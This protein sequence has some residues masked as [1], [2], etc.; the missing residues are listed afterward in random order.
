MCS[1]G[2]TEGS[3]ESV[4]FEQIVAGRLVETNNGREAS[5]QYPICE[6]TGTA[7]LG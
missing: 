7:K 4:D 3:R 6:V 1:S 2:M 5:W